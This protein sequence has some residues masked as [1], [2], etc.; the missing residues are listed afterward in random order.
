MSVPLSKIIISNGV[1]KF[2]AEEHL[3]NKNNII[4]KRGNKVLAF[5]RTKTLK[6]LMENTDLF[7]VL[8]NDGA[9]TKEVYGMTLFYRTIQNP[10]ELEEITF[11]YDPS[12]FNNYSVFEF[13]EEDRFGF[14]NLLCYTPASWEENK[15][16]RELTFDGV[17]HPMLQTHPTAIQIPPIQIPDQITIKKDEVPWEEKIDQVFAWDD[18]E[19][20]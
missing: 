15:P 16:L 11:Q 19:D 2:T 13:T 8:I 5:N 17:V 6:S 10:D 20:C 12:V 3:L 14:G 18:I 9:D 4:F 1:E 7:T